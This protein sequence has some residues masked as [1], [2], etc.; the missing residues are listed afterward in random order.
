MD[1]VSRKTFLITMA[2]LIVVIAVLIVLN[3]DQYNRQ[4]WDTEHPI[5]N[6]NISWKQTFHAGAW[7]GQV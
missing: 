1:P 7:G 4:T 6:T 2:V 5:V 3:I